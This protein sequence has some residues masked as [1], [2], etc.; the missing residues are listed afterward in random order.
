MGDVVAIVEPAVEI[1]PRPEMY[2]LAM[3]RTPRGWTVSYISNSRSWVDSMQKHEGQGAIVV[4]S[5][6]RPTP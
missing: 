5:A 4:I 6:E 2:G 3:Y 1:P